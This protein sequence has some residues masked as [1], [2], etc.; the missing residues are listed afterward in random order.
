MLHFLRD[1]SKVEAPVFNIPL[2]LSV[3]CIFLILE[4]TDAMQEEGELHY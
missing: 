1:D 3:F 2:I 4:D